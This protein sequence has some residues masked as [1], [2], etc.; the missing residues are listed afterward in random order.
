MSV[1]C[2]LEARQ[3]VDLVGKA[4]DHKRHI[5]EAVPGRDISEV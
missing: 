2:D 3:P 1:C 5:E 4:V